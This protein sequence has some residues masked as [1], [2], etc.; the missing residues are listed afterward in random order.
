MTWIL[1]SPM[2]SFRTSGP[3]L[4][5]RKEEGHSLTAGLDTQHYLLKWVILLLLSHSKEQ[6]NS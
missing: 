2:K 6:P 3:Q 1:T 4:E 5:E